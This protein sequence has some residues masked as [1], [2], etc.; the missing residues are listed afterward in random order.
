VRPVGALPAAGLLRGDLRAP[1]GV[2]LRD[3]GVS[4][5]PYATLNL[6]ASVGDDPAAVAENRRRVAQHFGVGVARVMRV[7]QVHGAAVEVAGEAN[8]GREAD[9]LVSDDPSWLLAVGAADCLPVLV[10]DT[11][12]GAVAAVH[13]GWRG[14]VAGVA[15]AAIARLAER[16]GSAAADLDVWF[17]PAIRGPCYQVGREVIEAVAA[18]GGDAAAWWPDPDGGDRYRLDVPALVRAQLVGAGVAP[19]RISDSGICTHCDP[20]CYSHRRDRG[21][22]GRHWAVIRA[23]RPDARG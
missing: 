7:D 16:F 10:H 4:V 17:G 14:A 20:R 3:G 1:H 5:A 8:L 23:V 6:G 21:R 13:A 22:T 19:E 15:P 18:A 11:R 2:T 12:L 9:A